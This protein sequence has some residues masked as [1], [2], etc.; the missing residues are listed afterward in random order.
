[1]AWRAPDTPVD[2]HTANDGAAK[3][4]PMTAMDVAMPAYD[5]ES[6]VV[7]PNRSMSGAATKAVPATLTSITK[8]DERTADV[9]PASLNI[10]VLK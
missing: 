8:S 7:R 9:T 3:Q 4:A 10:W 6:I 1:M 2:L 5:A